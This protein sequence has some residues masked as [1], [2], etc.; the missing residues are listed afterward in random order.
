M[1]C[2]AQGHEYTTSTRAWSFEVVVAKLDVSAERHRQI[3]RLVETLPDAIIVIDDAGI[4][5]FVNGAAQ[6]LFSKPRREFLGQLMNFSVRDGDV[7]EIEIPL[8]DQMR[9][10]EMRVVNWTWEGKP[11]QLAAIRDITDRRQIELQLHQAQKMEAIGNLTGGLAHDFNNL[12]AIVIGNLDLLSESPNTDARSKKLTKEALD[13][14]LRGADL[15]G[16]LL[17]FARRQPLAPEHVDT[18]EVV[19][20]ICELLQRTLGGTIKQALVLETGVWPV[21]VDPAQFESSLIN[22]ANNA[23]DAM[24][25][26]GTLTVATRNLVLTSEAVAA[27]PGAAPGEYV[28]IEISDSGTGMPPNLLNQIFE[29]FFTTKEE[30]KGTGLGLSMVFGFAQQSGGLVSVASEV[31]VGTTFR[32]MLPRSVVAKLP[33][34]ARRTERSE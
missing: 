15:V 18:N 1:G 24:P 23:R 33:A 9:I 29:P 26:G 2:G 7:I 30:G 31:G 14:A 34:A 11:A 16:R 25:N 27:Y 19:T 5:Q 10:A 22:I 8:D 13:A 6:M 12:L 17:A 21:L 28:V 32:L 4:V 3:E 20:R